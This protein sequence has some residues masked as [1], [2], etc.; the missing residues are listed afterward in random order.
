MQR[1][2]EADTLIVRVYNTTTS[3]KHAAI[4]CLKPIKE[5]VPTNLN[6]EPQGDPVALKDNMA[7]IRV[8][9]FRIVTLRVTV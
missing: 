4:T 6:E 5:I 2:E 9:P 7:T 3:E 1:G 8:A